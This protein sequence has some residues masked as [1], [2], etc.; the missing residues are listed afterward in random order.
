MDNIA[1]IYLIMGFSMQLSHP[2]TVIIIVLLCLIFLSVIGYIFGIC[3]C[4]MCA[5]KC[6][7]KTCKC[8]K[9]ICK[10]ICKPCCAKKNGSRKR[11]T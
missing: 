5:G 11:L 6:V 9:R 2:A 3:S 10:C 7:C 8:G 4:L 1:L